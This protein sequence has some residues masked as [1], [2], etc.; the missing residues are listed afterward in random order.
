MRKV[1]LFPTECEAAPFRALV[2]DAEI[3]ISGVGMAMTAATVARIAA[4]HEH[5]DMLLVLAGIAGA[6]GDIAVG[7]VVEVVS[8]C[9]VELPERFREH[10]RATFC[11]KLL[12]TATSNTVHGAGALAE[13]AE[14]ENMEGAALYV[15]A[16]SLR[17]SAT[18]IRA[19]SNR[20]GDHRSLWRID[21]ATQALARELLKI[22]NL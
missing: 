3:V 18:E 15:I 2:P 12:P 22:N 4:E 17:L 19:I 14:V 8:E 11:T 5:R 6:Y 9:C 13:G 10:H 1:Y 7:S 16:E 21:E 20:V